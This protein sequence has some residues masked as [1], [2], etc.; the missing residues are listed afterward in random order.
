VLDLITVNK[1]PYHIVLIPHTVGFGR[2]RSGLVYH[3]SQESDGLETGAD[4]LGTISA[5]GRGT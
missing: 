1:L 2:N 4:R 5:R 3:R